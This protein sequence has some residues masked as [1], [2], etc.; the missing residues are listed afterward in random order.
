[1]NSTREKIKRLNDLLKSNLIDLNSATKSTAGD[2]HETARA[3]IHI[4]QEN[5]S[6]QL[7]EAQKIMNL[8]TQINTKPKSFAQ[9]GA[10]IK[11][12]MGLF[13]MATGL[14]K[15][16]INKNEV[17]VI[18]PGSPIGQKLLGSAPKATVIFNKRNYYI[19]QVI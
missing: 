6:R 9:A 3:M 4:E 10:L 5:H 1:L 11:T 14:G 2:K 15:V 12:N 18:S 7:L 13:Y 8:L 19:E 16:L 17:Y